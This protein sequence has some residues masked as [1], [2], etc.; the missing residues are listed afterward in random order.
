MLDVE[1]FLTGRRSAP[2]IDRVL[3]TVLFTDIVGS[4]ERLSQ[5][6]DDRWRSEL[7]KHN[8]LVRSGLARWRGQEVK[9]V[10]DGFVAT[11]DGPARA[12]SCAAEIVEGVESL[13]MRVRAG[14]HTG[15]CE[16]R[17]DDVAGIPV[18]IAARVMHAAGPGE[19]LASSTVKELVIGSGLRFAD[20]GAHTFKGVEDEWRL[21]AL[22]R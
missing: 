10:G 21:Y 3:A 13:G 6:G 12:V 15:E 4:T 1:E 14:V 18:H 17:D 2:R 9:T 8:R 11:F 7:E 16:L 5:L 19:V 20:R 22:E